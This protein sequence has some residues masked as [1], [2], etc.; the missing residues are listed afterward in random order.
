MKIAALTMDFLP[1]TGG[2][3][4]YLYEILNRLGKVHEVVVVTPVAGALPPSS[5]ISRIILNRNSTVSYWRRARQLRPERILVGH[6]HPRLL[7]AARLCLPQD[8]ATVTYGNDFLAAQRGWHRPIFNYLLAKSDPLI[9]ITNANAKRLHNLGLPKAIVIYPGTDPQRFVPPATVKEST[10]PTL[11]TVSRLVPRKGIDLVIK[12][13]PAL[14]EGWPGLQYIVIGDGPDRERL[15][16]LTRQF[17]V[18]G[19]VRFLGRVS[20]A[21][22]RQ[23]YHQADV[24]VMPSR[25]I[26]ESGSVEG[27]GIVYLEAGACGLPVVAGRSGGAVE[28]VRHG[29]TGFLVP[30]DDADALSETLY[31]PTTRP[32]SWR[33]TGR[34]RRT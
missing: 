32:R 33:A 15:Q 22:L 7:L 31:R 27:F 26:V 6:A 17:D 19:T 9:T 14:L 1:E 29:E 4:I 8:Y 11:L 20:E 5:T 13:L 28:A 34:S 10:T 21:Q 24:F 3:Q 25:E 16:N 12:S 30:P 2:V 23:Q 18:V